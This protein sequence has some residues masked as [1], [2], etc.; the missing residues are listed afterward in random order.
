MSEYPE[1]YPDFAADFHGL[2]DFSKAFYTWLE[3]M[4]VQQEQ[5]GVEFDDMTRKRRPD[6][7]SW[8]E[9]SILFASVVDFLDKLGYRIYHTRGRDRDGIELCIRDLGELP[10]VWASLTG[11]AELLAYQPEYCASVMRRWEQLHHLM[12]ADAVSAYRAL[13]AAQTEGR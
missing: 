11:K 8:V 4:E 10:M 3:M 12:P 7:C 6:M 2:K 13:S 9:F 5:Q 1:Y